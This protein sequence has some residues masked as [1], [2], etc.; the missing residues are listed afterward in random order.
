VIALALVLVVLF[1]LVFT[2][3]REH[4]SAKERTHLIHLLT[5]STGEVVALERNAT[6]KTEE[7]PKP[8]PLEGLS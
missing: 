8:V 4:E 3:W 7:R 6:K 5:R 2:A 1:L